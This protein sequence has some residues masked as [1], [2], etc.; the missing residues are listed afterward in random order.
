M[1]S[2]AVPQLLLTVVA[3][4]FG[5]V[6]TAADLNATHA[7]NPRWTG[8]ARF[9]VVWQCGTHITV[10]AAVLALVWVPSPCSRA[11]MLLAAALCA[12]VLLSFF[13]AAAA[14]RLYGGQLSDGNGYRPLRCRI[15]RRQW[16]VDLNVLLFSFAA[17][18]LAAAVAY[19]L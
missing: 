17:A 16:S 3:L 8:H 19:T 9:H 18:V 5:V 12:G 13:L 15:G 11:A 10:C 4:S 14:R 6:A 2:A 7:C 1:S